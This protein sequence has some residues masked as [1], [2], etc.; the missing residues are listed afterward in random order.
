[1]PTTAEEP[2]DPG[3][4]VASRRAALV[5]LLAVPMASCQ[6]LAPD[7]PERSGSTGASALALVEQALADR[8]Q[9]V[10]TGDRAAFLAGL[11][12]DR[13]FRAEQ[14][15]WFDNLA[16]FPLQRFRYL[17]VADTVTD[18]GAEVTMTAV[19]R[20]QLREYDTR[21]VVMRQRLRFTRVGSSLGL[22][23]VTPVGDSGI[24]V[25]P[26]DAGPVMV[27]EG[28]GV[29]GIF[30]AA[31]VRQA[32]PVLS[33]V[34]AGMGVVAAH[35]PQPWSRRVVVYALS[36]THFFESLPNLPGGDPERLDGV[37][38]AVPA[39][40]GGHQMA[41]YRFMLHPRMLDRE[42]AA[43]DR[44][45]RHELTHVALGGHDRH[46]PLWLNEGLAEWISVQPI[47]RESRMIAR[48]ALA[49]ARRGVDGFPS[50]EEFNTGDSAANY[51]L[52]WWACEHI[53][54]TAGE[55]ALWR[56]FDAFAAA[57]SDADG[58]AVLRRVL[59]YDEAALATRAARRI[60]ATFG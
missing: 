13:D 57:G 25:A 59:G 21:P 28:S 29:L 38:F 51:G 9:V 56:L 10:R 36:D 55:Q 3:L 32:L 50:D 7:R 33:A 24:A 2:S 23:G 43:R 41:A 27:R 53:V 58:D 8:S 20:V 39:R 17:P 30:D 42:G 19:L 1:M 60:V 14:G 11:V 16:Q 31:S 26:W 49:L 18:L 52:A 5:A 45:I 35:V 22:S 12:E 4:I 44:L 34:E 48:E 37:T 46:V 6:L 40:P 54:A 15:V 47:P